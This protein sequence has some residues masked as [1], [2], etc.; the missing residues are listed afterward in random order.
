MADTTAEKMNPDEATLY[1]EWRHADGIFKP[2]DVA[3]Y[4]SFLPATQ[5]RPGFVRVQGAEEGLAS[6]EVTKYHIPAGS[7]TEVLNCKIKFTKT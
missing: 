7:T 3:K 5:G 2:E 4:I 1:D 6:A